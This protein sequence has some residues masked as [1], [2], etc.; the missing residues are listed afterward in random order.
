MTTFRRLAPFLAGDD[1][2]GAALVAAEAA[3]AADDVVELVMVEL[4][5]DL[6]DEAVD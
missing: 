6:L 4:M 5:L 2:D 3:L 1:A